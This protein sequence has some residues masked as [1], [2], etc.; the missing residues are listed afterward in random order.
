MVLSALAV[1]CI[2]CGLHSYLHGFPVD[3]HAAVLPEVLISSPGEET[4]QHR[5]AALRIK[6][7]SIMADLIDIESFVKRP[8]PVELFRR[9]HE[10]LGGSWSS[11]IG[12]QSPSSSTVGEQSA[13]PRGSSFNTSSVFWTRGLYSPRRVGA[14]PPVTPTATTRHSS[15]SSRTSAPASTDRSENNKTVYPHVEVEAPFAGIYRPHVYSRCEQSAYRPRYSKCH[16]AASPSVCRERCD[17]KPQAPLGAESL[18]INTTTCGGFDWLVHKHMLEQNLPGRPDVAGYCCLYY[19]L[20]EGPTESRAK[21]F[22]EEKKSL[23]R[24]SVPLPSSS[25]VLMAVFVR[26]A[27]QLERSSEGLLDEE[28]T[29]AITYGGTFFPGLCLGRESHSSKI[30]RQLS[31]SSPSIL[32]VLRRTKI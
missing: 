32:I 11:T 3:F 12:E 6:L 24:D 15:L 9:V 28:Y 4:T 29:S 21:V 30:S 16:H 8:D 7:W 14:R 23:A 1:A 19:H 26:A 13:P 2:T 5:P 20:S 10:F 31:F 22:F 17:F 25:A 18:R 27:L